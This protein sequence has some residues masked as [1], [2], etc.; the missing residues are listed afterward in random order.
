MPPNV[1]G[2]ASGHGTVAQPSEIMELRLA[3]GGLKPEQWKE[4]YH[5]FMAGWVKGIKHGIV[6]V[7]P[8]L[9]S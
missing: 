3:P 6:W 2:A 9:P 5:A 1:A 4:R 7:G 8:R